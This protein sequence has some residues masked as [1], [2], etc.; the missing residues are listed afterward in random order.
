LAAVDTEFD[1]ATSLFTSLRSTDPYRVEDLDVFSNIL[2]VSEKRAELA[3]LAHDYVQVDRLRPEVCCLVGESASFARN[4][5]SV[6]SIRCGKNRLR[7]PIGGRTHSRTRRSA[8]T[9]NYYSLRRDHEKAIAY[10]RRALK[11]DRNYLSA[12]TLMGHEYVEIKN[13]NAAIASYRRAVGESLGARD[14]YTS[15][16]VLGVSSAARLAHLH[17]YS[18]LSLSRRSRPERLPRVVRPRPGL[19]AARRALLRAQLLQPRDGAQAL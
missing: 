17:P 13:T 6:A 7:S 14:D 5:W 16:L 11:L 19:R 8:S 2:Y 9:G 12:W 1:D 18:P 15:G 4:S 10:F 3:A